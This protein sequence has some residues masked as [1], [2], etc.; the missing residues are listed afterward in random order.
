LNQNERIY[1]NFPN[2]IKKDFPEDFPLA[3][4]AVE[5]ILGAVKQADFSQ[6][7]LRSPGLKGNDWESYL[8]CSVVRVVRAV[9]AL[10]NLGI[11]SG[12][13]LDLGAYFGNF[14]LVF[15]GKGFEVDACDSYK[16]YDNALN[17]AINLLQK[18]GVNILDFQDIGYNLEQIQPETYDVVL[19]MGVIEHIPHTPRFLLESINRV[20]KLGGILL[21]D[22]PNLTYI[23]N[24]RKF[25]R[26]ESVF[27]SIFLQY[28]TELPFEGHHREYTVR[29]ILWMLEQIQHQPLD[30]ELFNYSYYGIDYLA[31]YDII[32]YEIMENNPTAREY[33]LSISKKSPNDGNNLNNGKK[34]S[35]DALKRIE[36]LVSN[37]EEI[38]YY[39]AMVAERD[40]LQA[41][42]NNLQAERDAL[43]VERKNLQTELGYIQN[44]RIY[45]LVRLVLQAGDKV[46]QIFKKE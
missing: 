12:R 17:G 16:N 1:L 25:M 6:L 36:A 20:L 29:E 44:R 19:C 14:S 30:I 18:S 41:Q 21:L 7:E 32:N 23:Y 2:C 34:I 3:W 15:A 5:Q 45:P 42:C 31:G 10:S 27:L 33:I 22:T 26:G 40:A 39:A 37:S 24:R 9:K 43:Q 4:D 38:D 46:K 11:K 35:E 8:R 28:Y 13:V